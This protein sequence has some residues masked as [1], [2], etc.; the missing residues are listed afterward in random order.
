MF[1]LIVCIN[2]RRLSVSQHH[3]MTFPFKNLSMLLIKRSVFLLGL[4]EQWQHMKPIPSESWH[5]ASPKTS[6]FAPH[7]RQRIALLSGFSLM[8]V[9]LL[10]VVD[11]YCFVFCE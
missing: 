9:S 11:D 4:T 2:S 6:I 5:S 3:Q 1:P 10:N 7:P 8:V